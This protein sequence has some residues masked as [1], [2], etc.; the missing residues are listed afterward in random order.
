MTVF[1]VRPGEGVGP[2]RLGMTR[3]EAREAMPDGRESFL[4]TPDSQHPTD[5]WFEAGFQVFYSDNPPVV[6]SIELSRDGGFSV[7]CW[8]IDVFSTPVDRVVNHFERYS[9]L[10]IADPEIGCSY[11]FPA[12]R[13]WVWRPFMPESDDDEHARYFSII[14]ISREDRPRRSGR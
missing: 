13:L 12:A 3:E 2:I 6:D 5:A 10:D 8:G 14:G 7:N 9:A 11:L 4:K 1:E